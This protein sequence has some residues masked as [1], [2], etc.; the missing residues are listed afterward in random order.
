MENN[1]AVRHE[2]RPGDSLEQVLNDLDQTHQSNH[3]KVDEIGCDATVFQA[4][5]PVMPD[6]VRP[7]THEGKVEALIKMYHKSKSAD[8]RSALKPLNMFIK[9]G[10]MALNGDELQDFF[11]Q[12]EAERVTKGA[13]SEQKVQASFRQ[14]KQA[15]DDVMAGIGTRTAAELKVGELKAI[16]SFRVGAKATNKLG[17]KANLV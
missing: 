12:A 5:L 15:H 13:A 3:A 16:L 10:T 8:P 9:V 14:V 11:L 17:K 4:S 6:V 2:R 1:P 7:K